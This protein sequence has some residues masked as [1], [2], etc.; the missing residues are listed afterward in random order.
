MLGGD[1]HAISVESLKVVIGTIMKLPFDDNSGSLNPS[2]I[3]KFHDIFRSFYLNKMSKKKQKVVTE[4]YSYRPKISEMSLKLVQ[5]RRNSGN[6]NEQRNKHEAGLMGKVR[7]TLAETM[8]EC[9][10]KPKINRSCSN[11]HNSTTCNR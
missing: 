1:K 10:F 6:Y 7:N 8:K 2:Q 4:I 9:T 5:E 11:S 3:A